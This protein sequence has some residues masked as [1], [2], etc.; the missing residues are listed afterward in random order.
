MYAFDD[1]EEIM[2]MLQMP[3]GSRLTYCYYRF[4]G[5][6]ADL[7]DEFLKRLSKFIPYLSYNFV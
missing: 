3:T 2:D 6:S 5:V 4:G 1:R 7:S